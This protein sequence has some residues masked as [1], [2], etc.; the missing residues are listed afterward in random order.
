MGWASVDGGV[1]SAEVRGSFSRSNDGCENALYPVESASSVRTSCS[2]P[3]REPM[4]LFFDKV[5]HC[6]Q[7]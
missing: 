4:L 6:Y 5:V 2:T 3:P 1:G 7:R